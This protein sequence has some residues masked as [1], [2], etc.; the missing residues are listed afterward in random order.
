MPRRCQAQ[1][2]GAELKGVVDQ[3]ITVKV[4]PAQFR[5]QQH[6]TQLPAAATAACQLLSGMITSSCFTQQALVALEAG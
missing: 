2:A 4:L 1:H 3:Q 5:Q 6:S